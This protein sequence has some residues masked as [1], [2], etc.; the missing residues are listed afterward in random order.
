MNFVDATVLRLADPAT[1][2][3]VFDDDA[4]GQLVAA[5]YDTGTLAVEGPF[6]AVFDDFHFGLPTRPATYVDGSWAPTGSATRTEIRLRV[7]GLGLTGAGRVDAVWR[8]AIVARATAGGGTVASVAASFPDPSGID[9]EIVDQTGSLPADPAALEAARRA[10]LLDRIKAAAAQPDAVTGA[11]LDDLL[12][13][14]GVTGVGE[15]LANGRGSAAGGAVQVTFAPAPATSTP[16][17][18]PLTALLLVRDV[19]FSV[20]DLL[21]ETALLRDLAASLGLERPD[22]AGLPRRTSLLVVWVV[23]PEVFDDDGWPGGT[24]GSAAERRAARRAAAGVLLARE[25]IGLVAAAPP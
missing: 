6:T 16:Q 15:L 9:Q 21:A 25:G 8:G 3:A 17:P 4:L 24:S 7:P 2:A 22:A 13:R 20:A 5:V 23:P 11:V 14:M 12:A 18:L 1:R 19:G 10:R